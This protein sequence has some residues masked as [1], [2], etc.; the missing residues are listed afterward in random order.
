MQPIYIY[1]C[2]E[3]VDIQYISSQCKNQMIKETNWIN[4]QSSGR[5]KYATMI[6]RFVVLVGVVRCVYDSVGLS[7]QHQQ[8]RLA[9]KPSKTRVCPLNV[10]IANVQISNIQI[11]R[12]HSCVNTHIRHCI[13]WWISKF[14][15]WILCDTF[16]FSKFDNRHLF[17]WMWR[18]ST[19]IN[20]RIYMIQYFPCGHQR[21]ARVCSHTCTQNSECEEENWIDARNSFI[22]N[23]NRSIKR[24]MNEI[25]SNKSGMDSVFVI[26]SNVQ[27]NNMLE[28]R[29][30]RKIKHCRDSHRKE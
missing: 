13:V 10:K 12:L 9:V 21:G 27:Q 29:R 20:A 25:C 6:N 17:N 16:F 19:T 1:F 3:P 15:V 8:K 28:V 26:Y 30:G 14:F 4:W 23:V 5:W 18:A 24:M 11:I 22:I 2:G 7:L